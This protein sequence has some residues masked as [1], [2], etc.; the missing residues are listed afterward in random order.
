MR[1]SLTIFLFLEVIPI[2]K[3]IIAEKPNVMRDFVH[4]LDSHAKGICYAKPYVYY[5][6]GTD[7]I[8]AAANGHLFQ[9]KNPEEISIN[10]KKWE[11]KKLDIPEIIPIKMN[12]QYAQSFHC[13]KELV[14]RKDID[15]IIVATD[16]DREGQLIWELIARNL[17]ITVPV[18]RIWI[19]EWTKASLVKA[20]HG[21]KDNKTYQNLANAG[22]ARLQA[23]YLIGMTG[24]R[25]HTVCFGGY[26]NVINEGRVQSPT[27]YLVGALEKTI[28]NFKPENYHII[29][30]QTESDDS[31]TMTLL[32]SKLDTEESIGLFEVLPS[33]QYKILK[34]VHKASKRGP[35]LYKTNDILMDA[36]NKLGLSAE[37]T[38]DILQKLYQDYALTTYPRTEIQQISVS[39]SKEI[40]KIVNSLEGVGLVDEIIDEIKSKH[41]T[42]QKHLINF[43][44][45]EMPHEAITPTYEGNPKATLSKLSNDERNVYELIVRRFLQGFY[46]EAIIEETKVA[47]VI[48][49]SGKNYTFSNSGKIIVEPSWM[50]VLGI[51]RDTYLP[52]ITDRKTYPYVNSLLERKTTKPPSRFTEATLLNAMENAARYVEDSSSKT[53]LKKSKGIGTGATRNEI[54][55]NLYKSG[56]IIKKGKTIYPTD[57]LMQWMEILPDSPLKSPMMTA[58]LESQLSEVEKGTLSLH[59]FMNSVNQQLD[60]L[61]K[62]ASESPKTIISS[63]VTKTS[64]K[65]V[66]SLD[67]LGNCPI[68]GKP[69]RENS[70]SFYCTGYKEGCKFS[71]WKEIKGKKISKRTAETLIHKGYTGKLKGFYSDKTGKDFEAK[72]K[73]NKSTQKVEFDFDKR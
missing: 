67:S 5:Y 58:D 57:K 41:M 37:K 72:L 16:P 73:I 13:L 53:I 27:R 52:A 32:S 65:D 23:D 1:C 19:S 2:K 64:T 33:Y 8:F 3:L 9:A 39:A 44:E 20:F 7:F 66:H 47:T 34:D 54:I 59:S 51:P 50:K 22:L 62:V 26:K 28:M 29:Q 70:K 11:A 42:F 55:K 30:L 12:K 49:Y 4:A 31:E 63:G 45:G 10:N 36:N 60:E 15:E 21:R 56:F 6:E 68:C 25:V 40:M 18:T 14:Q 48:S 69:M 24:T 71:I 38:T 46:P 17:K 61:I 43:S 35:K